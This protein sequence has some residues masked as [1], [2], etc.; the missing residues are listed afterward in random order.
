MR[1]H[2]INNFLNGV[3]KFPQLLTKQFLECEKCIT[4]KE[5]FEALRSMP[6]DKSPGN[7]GLTK[8]SLLVKRNSAH[9]KD[10]QLLN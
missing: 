2:D 9:H 10:K 1:Q 4:E 5:P 7:D 3:S 6:N 8:E